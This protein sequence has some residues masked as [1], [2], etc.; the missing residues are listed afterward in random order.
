MSDDSEWNRWTE[1]FLD[2]AA[3]ASP[4]VAPEK[5]VDHARRET[6]RMA[7]GLA[8]EVVAAVGVVA[9]WVWVVS[10]RPSDT[11]VAMA[12]ASFAFMVAWVA[13]LVHV[14]RSAWSSHGA[15]VRDHMEL[16]LRRRHAEARWFTFAQA[17]T[18]LFGLVVA[19]WAPFMLR[20]HW[21]LY[22][23]EPWRAIVGFGTAFAILAACLVYYG[24]RRD[25]AR[26]EARAWAKAL[27][28]GEK[29]AAP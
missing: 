6:R 25:R 8:A 2:D 27:E 19:A 3:S 17:A 28:E 12:G 10:R 26:R 9:F 24:R 21:A 29:T 7:L 11:V 1:D 22:R 4:P 5:L 16:A 15:S 18:A 20:A 23:A 14:Q 13:Y